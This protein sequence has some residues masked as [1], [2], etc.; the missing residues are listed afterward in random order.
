M[1]QNESVKNIFRK[2]SLSSLWKVFCCFHFL[3][4]SYIYPRTVLGIFLKKTSFLYIY[5]I[6]L[7]AEHFLSPNSPPNT[8]KKDRKKPEFINKIYR[9]YTKTALTVWVHLWRRDPVRN[10]WWEGVVWC[11]WGLIDVPPPLV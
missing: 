5:K 9:Q 1:Q 4:F 7:R 3:K 8:T 6:L 11:M 10:N 2:R